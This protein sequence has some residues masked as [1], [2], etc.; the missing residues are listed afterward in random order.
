[1]P[2]P[3]PG[4]LNPVDQRDR[5]GLVLLGQQD[6]GDVLDV[7]LV[8]VVWGGLGHGYFAFLAGGFFIGVFLAGAWA[9]GAFFAGAFF[10][11]DFLA[12][13]FLAGTF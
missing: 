1:M 13:A 9:A 12:G 5:P 4:I 10:A 11:G 2:S 7:G 3:R 6:V 8:R